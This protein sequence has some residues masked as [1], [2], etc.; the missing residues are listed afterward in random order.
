M[1]GKAKSR[2]TKAD[3]TAI[4]RENEAL[5]VQVARYA[6]ENRK[7]HSFVGQSRGCRSLSDIIYSE[8]EI[9]DVI[10][11][12]GLAIMD[13]DEYLVEGEKPQKR[14]TD[15][16]SK[17]SYHVM[18]QGQIARRH[19]HFA[20][21]N[22]GK[23]LD[24]ISSPCTNFP[25]KV[26]KKLVHMNQEYLLGNT[27]KSDLIM[28]CDMAMPLLE[29]EPRCIRLQS[30]CHVFGDIHG[31]MDELH[32][33]NEVIWTKGIHL[34]P[35]KFVFLGDYVDRGMR[36]LECVA[37]LL[38]MKIRNPTKVYLLRGNHELRDVNSWDDFYGEKCLIS[39][40][41]RRFG[42]DSGTQIWET[43]NQV[44]DRLPLAAII[45]EDIFCIHGGI[46]RP[47]DGVNQVD[48]IMQVPPVAGIAPPYPHE[49]PV[50]SHVAHQCLWSDPV[51][52][53]EETRMDGAG[54]GSNPRGMKAQCFGRAAIDS[55]LSQNDLSYIIRAH[56][57]TVDGMSLSKDARVITVFSTSKDHNLGQQ[58]LAACLLID[59]CRIEV[60]TKDP[61]YERMVRIFSQSSGSFQAQERFSS[62]N[63]R[64]SDTDMFGLHEDELRRVENYR[65]RSIGLQCQSNPATM[66]SDLE[67]PM[68]NGG[69]N[70]SVEHLNVCNRDNNLDNTVSD[71]S[72][73]NRYNLTAMVEEASVFCDI[74][75]DDSAPRCM[76]MNRRDSLDPND[77]EELRT[78]S[79]PVILC[80]IS[81]S[82]GVINDK[83]RFNRKGETTDQ[84][85][86]ATF[87][88]CRDQKRATTTSKPKVRETRNRFIN[89]VSN[90]AKHK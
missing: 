60:I 73:N 64:T 9:G 49:H 16:G 75:N 27:F 7:R 11:E 85:S 14:K 44:F 23:L 12:D 77:F 25:E 72:E 66:D 48:L 36:G 53:D 32:F 84:S 70:N 8:E 56:E 50:L 71:D 6:K 86:A 15:L 78:K 33:Y 41:W 63:V 21:E 1:V 58:A 38:A 87:Q 65:K 90:W 69:Y 59:D 22:T 20:S 35:G 13:K 28:L 40:C 43:I 67:T 54:F 42:R 10:P 24:M 37:Y 34:T 31:N 68:E 76:D 17:M 18:N 2:P 61:G 46:P 26:M 88:D 83:D 89:A 45:D 51:K 79:R 47:V 80:S 4:V 19:L 39:Q 3:Y 29:S 62:Y 74:L 55:F 57:K 5:K 30:P 52:N 81:V 82:E